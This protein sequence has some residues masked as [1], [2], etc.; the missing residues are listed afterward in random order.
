MR[1]EVQ[2]RLAM[3]VAIAD[4]PAT[5]FCVQSFTSV[6]RDG[7]EKLGKLL[8]RVMDDPDHGLLLA[9]GTAFVFAFRDW[10]GRSGSN[11]MRGKGATEALS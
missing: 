7:S 5:V 10:L 4:D 6:E 3:A 8:A 1:E 9:T 11:G 2:Q